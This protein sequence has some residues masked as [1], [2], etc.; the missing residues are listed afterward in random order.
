MMAMHSPC[1]I[2]VGKQYKAANWVFP[3]PLSSRDSSPP[4]VRNGLSSTRH[5]LIE[6][7]SSGATF[8]RRDDPFKTFGATAGFPHKHDGSA[9]DLRSVAIIEAGLTVDAILDRSKVCT[10]GIDGGGLDDL[11]G[12]TVRDRENAVAD[13]IA[14]PASSRR[15]RASKAEMKR[16]TG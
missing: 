4:I 11:P 12:L 5:G 14:S 10:I 2:S 9:P 16:S 8:T 3:N 1:P 6:A 15:Q 13:A 7:V